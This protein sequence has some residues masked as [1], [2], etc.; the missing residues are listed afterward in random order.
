Q[1]DAQTCVLSLSHF[2]RA[3]DCRKTL[4]G[5][6]T[7]LPPTNWQRRDRWMRGER[8]LLP[9]VATG[10]VLRWHGPSQRM[11][12]AWWWPIWTAR[13]PKRWRARS[14]DEPMPAT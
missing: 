7:I 12:R 6:L 1:A 5:G 3:V 10:S 9:A 4:V 11:V 13:L 8:W 14:A 2:V